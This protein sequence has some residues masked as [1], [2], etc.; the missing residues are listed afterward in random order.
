MQKL[1]MQK[2]TFT[3]HLLVSVAFSLKKNF[4]GTYWMI[5]K[6]Q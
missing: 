4:G 3:T 1:K 6:K 5:D 2:M